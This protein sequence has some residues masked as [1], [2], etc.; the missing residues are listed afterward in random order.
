MWAAETDSTK[1][2]IFYTDGAAQ[3]TK[4]WRRRVASAGWGVVVFGISHDGAHR[5]LLG[6]AC[7]PCMLEGPFSTSA[8]S[9]PAAELT[10][11]AAVGPLLEEGN[12]GEKVAACQLECRFDLCPE[13]GSAKI[14]GQRQ[15]CHGQPRAWCMVNGTTARVE[16]SHVHSRTGE[17]G[18]ECV[19]V[20]AELDRRGLRWSPSLMDRLLQRV[21]H[22]M[23]RKQAK[24]RPALDFLLESRSGQECRDPTSADKGGPSWTQGR[25]YQAEIGYG[26]CH[27]AVPTRREK[28]GCVH[29]QTSVGTAVSQGRVSSARTPRDKGEELHTVQVRRVARRDSG[30]GSRQDRSRSL[31]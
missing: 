28:C 5:R 26:E 31:A 12:S 10:A 14:Q 4:A 16:T 23:T 25:G 20:L 15:H 22:R 30:G 24:A 19:D 29:S 3:L 6:A 27:D 11:A 17:L 9:A 8:P 13:C 2:L 18:N 7:A 21:H 1:E